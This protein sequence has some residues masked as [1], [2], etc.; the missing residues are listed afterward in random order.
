[1]AID[2]KILAL[3][4]ELSESTSADRID[5]DKTDDPE[6]FAAS[7]RNHKVSLKRGVD[8]NRDY[9][10]DLAIKSSFPRSTIETVMIDTGEELELATDLYFAARRKALGLDPTLDQMLADL[11]AIRA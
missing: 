4:E 9:Y 2:P 11:R 5:W 6:T 7:F 8:L 1:M 10:F 3:I